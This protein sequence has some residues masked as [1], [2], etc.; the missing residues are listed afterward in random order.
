MTRSSSQIYA[1]SILPHYYF[2]PIYKGLNCTPSRPQEKRKIFSIHVFIYLLLANKFKK[3]IHVL[4][5]PFP[6]HVLVGHISS[7]LVMGPLVPVTHSARAP[8]F[9]ALQ[10]L[11]PSFH[12]VLQAPDSVVVSL[13]RQSVQETSAVIPV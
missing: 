7:C 5:V 8:T 1:I 10:R 11:P 3:S 13:Q 12:V 2:N 4:G 6:Q 9:P